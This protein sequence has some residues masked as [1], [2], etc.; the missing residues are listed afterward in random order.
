MRS[1]ALTGRQATRHTSQKSSCKLP[2]TV[3]S[4]T[5]SPYGVNTAEGSIRLDERLLAEDQNGMP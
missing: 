3:T 4:P 2:N 5:T 1:K